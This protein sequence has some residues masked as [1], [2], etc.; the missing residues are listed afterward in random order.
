MTLFS[1]KRVE[2]LEHRKL[3]TELRLL[4][5]RP[6]SGGRGDSIDHAP[7]A[8]DDS[9]NACAGALWQASKSKSIPIHSGARLRPAYSIT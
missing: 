4:E 5:R 1:Q 2:L 7:R 9:A 8:H 6:R 3:L